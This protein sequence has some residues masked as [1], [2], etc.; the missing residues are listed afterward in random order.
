VVLFPN[1]VFCVDEGENS[2]GA[3]VTYFGSSDGLGYVYQMDVGTSFDGAAINAYITT[4]WNPIGSP[5]ILKRFR[6]ASIEMQG[7]AYARSASAI[8]SATARR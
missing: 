8:S 2:L 5:R 6:A 7:T 1:P 3:E 4:A